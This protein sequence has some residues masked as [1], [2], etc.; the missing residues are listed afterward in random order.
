V[1]EGRNADRLFHE[2]VL[3]ATGNEILGTLASGIAA[4]VRWTT[5]FKARDG[6]MPRDPV[7]EHEAVLLAIE[8]G[9]ATLARARMTD[10]VQL[11]LQDIQTIDSR[12]ASPAEA[13]LAVRA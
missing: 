11:A 13:P 2:T 1:E 4:A 8:A 12:L 3:Q 6:Q 7:P 9:D 10:L 5:M